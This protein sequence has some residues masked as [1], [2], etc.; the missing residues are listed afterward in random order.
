MINEKKEIGEEMYVK[1]IS[2]NS[3][4]VMAACSVCRYFSSVG[5]AYAG[6]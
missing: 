5:L 1:E 6:P 2:Q 3:G 4:T